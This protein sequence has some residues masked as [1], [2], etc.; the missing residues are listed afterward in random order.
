MKQKSSILDDLKG[1]WA[2]LWLNGMGPTGW[3]KKTHTQFYFWDNFDN[4]IIDTI[5][6]ET[7]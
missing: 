2:L 5:I 6:S 4:S 1:R 7:L 3:S